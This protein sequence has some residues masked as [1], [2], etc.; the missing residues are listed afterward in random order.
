MSV[1]CFFKQIWQPALVL[2]CLLA[3]TA[4]V[5]ACTSG[6]NGSASGMGAVSVMLSDPATCATPDGPFSHVFVTVVDVKANVSSTAGDTDSG[7]VD[8]TPNLSKAPKQGGLLATPNDQSFLASL[9]AT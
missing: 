4:I 1:Q 3:V 5:V 6:S 9:G 2:G 7:W 8:L